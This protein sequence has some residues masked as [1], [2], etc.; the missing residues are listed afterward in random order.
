[1]EVDTAERTGTAFCRKRCIG[2]L[3]QQQHSKTMSLFQGT[4]NVSLQRG[5]PSP[6]ARAP[7]WVQMAAQHGFACRGML[8]PGMVATASA[9]LLR[10]L[11]QLLHDFGQA[12]LCLSFP[13]C[14]ME[15]RVLLFAET[16]L[17]Q[18]YRRQYS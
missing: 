2:V 6:F 18:E 4:Q 17:L 1:M 9:L 8:P 11:R 16:F 3:R 10:A 12:I 14:K 13:N 7:A 15:E 5:L